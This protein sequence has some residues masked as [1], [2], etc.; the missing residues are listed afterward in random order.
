MRSNMI[1]LQRAIALK[2][3]GQRARELLCEGYPVEADRILDEMIERRD[4]ME[5]EKV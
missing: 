5:R 3:M 4:L 2:M 1:D